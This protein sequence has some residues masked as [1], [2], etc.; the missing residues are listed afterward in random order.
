MPSGPHGANDTIE[1]KNGDRYVGERD[2]L[3]RPH[4]DG[5]YEH[6]DKAYQIQQ[7]TYVGKW[8]DGNMCGIGTH[9]YR[10][11]DHYEGPWKNDKRDGPNGSYT[12]YT[13]GSKRDMSERYIGDWENNKKHGLGLMTF[14]NGDK[15]EGF[16]GHG[17]MHT[18]GDQKGTYTFADGS[19]YTGKRSIYL[20]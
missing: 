19:V 5:T 6:H 10:I 14:T 11:G 1:Y 7:G 2:C 12:Y 8:K 20:D 9:Q 3:G 4:G 15:Y 17:N 13:D 18:E 16:W